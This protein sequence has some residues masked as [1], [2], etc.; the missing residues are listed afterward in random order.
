MRPRPHSEFHFHRAFAEIDERHTFLAAQRPHG[1]GGLLQRVM[2][3]VSADGRCRIRERFAGGEVDQVDDHGMCPRRPRRAVDAAFPFRD[4]NRS[5]QLV[6]ARQWLVD[7]VLCDVGSPTAEDFVD[8]DDQQRRWHRDAIAIDPVLP[9]VPFE[10]G[11]PA[12]SARARRS[13]EAIIAG[14]RFV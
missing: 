14:I 5:V 8:S 6:C 1:D 2:C 13:G 12:D 3:D 10:I 4:R 7:D 9:V 11:A